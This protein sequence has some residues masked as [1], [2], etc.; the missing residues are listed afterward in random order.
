LLKKRWWCDNQ[1]IPEIYINRSIDIF[2]YVHAYIY[3]QTLYTVNLIRWLYLETKHQFICTY[4][5]TFIYLTLSIHSSICSTSIHLSIHSFIYPFSTHQYI[6]PSVYPSIY[7]SIHQSIYPSI[8]PFIY[9]SIHL[10]IITPPL[11]LYN[12]HYRKY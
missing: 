3:K 10:S 8:H 11:Q 2:I 6:Y 9:P 12:P 4:Y 1:M 7:I 5:I